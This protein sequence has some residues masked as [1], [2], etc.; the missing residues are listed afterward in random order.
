MTGCNGATWEKVSTFFRPKNVP[1]VCF[2]EVR[3]DRT[4]SGFLS[5]KLPIWPHKKRE[6]RSKRERRLWR[7][8]LFL[9]GGRSHGEFFVL[10][11][12]LR[13]CFLSNL[14]LSI[15]YTLFYWM[16]ILRMRYTIL[17]CNF[18]AIIFTVL[19]GY[20]ETAEPS[21]RLVHARV[22]AQVLCQVLHAGSQ[23]HWGRVHQVPFWPTDQTRFGNG[24]I[25]MQRQYGSSHGLI[26]CPRYSFTCF[27]FTNQV[28]HM[29]ICS[30]RWRR[31][32]Y[33]CNISEKRGKTRMTS[34]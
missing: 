4:S 19:V 9:F 21:S 6:G 1:T 26:H 8:F 30:S 17:Q 14:L 13:L 31:Y 29:S 18:V 24:S 22:L 3:T 33:L 28:N 7:Y 11:R 34:S 32:C 16:S 25:T 20:R 15:W 2:K 10:W 23:P 5:G 27:I 12:S